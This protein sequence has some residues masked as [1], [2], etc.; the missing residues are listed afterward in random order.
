[1]SSSFKDFSWIFFIFVGI[2]NSGNADFSVVVITLRVED[3]SDATPE[4]DKDFIEGANKF[5]IAVPDNTPYGQIIFQAKVGSM[6]IHL[7]I[8]INFYESQ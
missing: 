6:N 3:V 1:M 8:L 2:A 5:I 7:R 4:F